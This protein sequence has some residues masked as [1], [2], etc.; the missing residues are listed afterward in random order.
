MDIIEQIEKIGIVPVVKINDAEKAEGLAEALCNGGLPCA[1]VTFRTDAAA[2]AIKLITTKFPEMCVGAGTVLTTAQVDA[3]V[4]AGAKFIVSPGLNPKVVSYCV[5]KNIPIVPGISTPSEIEQAIELGL[6]VVKFFPA[7][8]SGGLAKI[9]AMAAP[10][11]GVRFMPTGGINAANINSYLD[12]QK[13]VACGGSWM[14]PSDALDAGD[15]ERIENLAREAVKTMLG[16]ELA[17]V[18]INAQSP[19]EAEKAAKRFSFLFGLEYKPGNSSIFA[20]SAVEVMKTPYLGK[21]GHIA[22]RTNYIERAM[23]YL[24]S[25]LGVKFNQESAKKDDKTGKLKAIYLQ[26]EIGG[27]AVHLVQK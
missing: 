3:A 25:V 13:I 9:K 26:E 1:E 17:H 10:Y 15:F 8:Q 16:F 23:N 2:E 4:S 20:G 22:I 24:S 12:F 19:D 6:S 18:G 21:N 7:E 5:S 11:A 27:F 14:V